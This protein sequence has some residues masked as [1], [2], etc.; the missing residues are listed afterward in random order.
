MEK[1]HSHVH[2][3]THCACNNPVLNILKDAIFS[4]E[5]LAKIKSGAGQTISQQPQTLMISGGIIRPMTGGST[6]PVEAIGIANGNVVVTGDQNTVA[7]YM[8]Q[9]YPGYQTKQLTG[10]Q[11]LLPGLIEPHVHIVPTAIM[12]GWIDVSPFNGQDLLSTYDL[13]TVGATINSNIPK[14]LGYI[15]LGR[16]LDP[17]LMP[18]VQVGGVN[19]LQ[20]IDNTVLDAINSDKSMM[21]LSASMHTLYLNTKALTYVYDKSSTVQGQYASANDYIQ[22]THGQLQEEA[23]M[24]PALTVV[25]VQILLMSDQVDAYLTSLFQ[26]ANSRGV[27]FMYDAAMSTDFKGLLTRHLTNNPALVR[28]GGALLCSN[29]DE[30]NDLSNYTPVTNYQ[31]VYYGHV[32]LVSDGSNQGLTGYQ[33]TPYLCDPP[34]NSGIF[35]FPQEGIPP[36][37]IPPDYETLINTVVADKGWPLMVHANGDL[38]VTF[39]IEAYQNTL[40]IYKGPVLRNRIEHCSLITTAQL[41]TM[42]QMGVSPSFLIGHVGYWGYAFNEVIFGQKAQMLDLCN[43]ALAAGLRITLHSD[44]EVSPLGPLRMMEQ[45]ITRIMEEYTTSNEVL[46]AAECL[47]PEQAL[48][49]VTYDAAWQCYADQWVGSL[50]AGYFAD[51]VILEQDPLSLTT[52]STQYMQMRNIPVLETW[53]GGVPVYLGGG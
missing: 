38:A 25:I 8:A 33:S 46:N 6:D 13:T 43:S 40:S 5:N 35:N 51:F 19:E 47:T 17:S 36:S 1:R 45:S 44:N 9:N 50:N 27:T 3:C 21:L 10:T 24:T 29:Q 4:P 20:T 12:T 30:A 14:T 7:T 2:G 16:G 42:Q 23:E 31:P 49:A 52:Q 53:L 37:T 22:A 11:T 26:L 48:V 39:A 41:A 32:K 15:I 18:F 34:D 28:I